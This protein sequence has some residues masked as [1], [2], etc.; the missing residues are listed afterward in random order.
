MKKVPE[1]AQEVQ[2]SYSSLKASR[3]N[4]AK[5]LKMAETATDRRKEAEKVYNAAFE[6]HRKAL[7]E[8]R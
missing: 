1:T 4:E 3:T 8:L 7:K 6:E 5:L 2:K